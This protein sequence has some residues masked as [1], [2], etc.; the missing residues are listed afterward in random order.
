MA[1]KRVN[2]PIQAEK[3][4]LAKSKATFK[5]KLDEQIEMGKKMLSL[6]V[7]NKKELM[8]LEENCG[9]WND[10]N[11][12]LIKQSFDKPNNSCFIQYT[13]SAAKITKVGARYFPPS[14]NERIKE[15]KGKIKKYLTRLRKI[16]GK[17]DLFE[18]V[19]ASQ[20][21]NVTNPMDSAFQFLEKVF[22]RFHKVAQSLKK[23]HADRTT[24]IIKDEYDVQDLLQS[25]LRIGFED[26]RKEEYL[27]SYAGSNSRMD[28]LLKEEGIVIETKITSDKLKEKGLGD[29][30]LIDI[31]RYGEHPDC[32]LLVAFIYDKDEQDSNEVYF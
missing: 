32:K 21:K 15:V 30:L 6:E 26:I 23:R 28:F 10:Y 4:Y 1:Q 31:A 3:E 24:L 16:R 14:P 27:P 25:L 22:N 9:I 8:G 2:K 11:A 29:E 7:K 5:T 18:E 19:Q 20:F 12:E 17:V 13:A